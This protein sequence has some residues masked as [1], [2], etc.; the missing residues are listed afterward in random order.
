M[1]Q[2][3]HCCGGFSRR[4]A[5]KILPSLGRV[6]IMSDMSQKPVDLDQQKKRDYRQLPLRGAPMTLHEI[7]GHSPPGLLLSLSTVGV[8]AHFSSWPAYYLWSLPR[9]RVPRAWPFVHVVTAQSL[10]PRTVP[11]PRH[12][13][14]AYL[15]HEQKWTWISKSSA[16]CLR[17]Q[18]REGSVTSCI[19][20]QCTRF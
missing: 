3:S 2:S 18:H 10:A 17:E 11:G 16:S 13:C 7:P 6:I 15:L 4:M 20:L 19:H 12:T 9:V 5:D 1:S 14:G 8:G